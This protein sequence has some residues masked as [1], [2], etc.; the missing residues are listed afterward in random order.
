LPAPLLQLLELLDAASARLT[1]LRETPT[2]SAILG[3]TAWY[4]RV[5]M[6]RIKV[7]TMYRLKA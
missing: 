5:E 2:V 7:P 1:A 6:P 3:N 4:S